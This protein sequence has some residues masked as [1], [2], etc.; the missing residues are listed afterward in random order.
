MNKSSKS[1]FFDLIEISKLDLKT[2]ELLR[3]R[4]QITPQII[5]VNRKLKEMRSSCQALLDEIDTCEK[6][7]KVYE[8]EIAEFL[9]KVTASKAKVYDIKTNEAYKMALKEID[10][11]EHEIKQREDSIL[12][13]MRVLEKNQPEVEK[14]KEKFGPEEKSLLEQEKSFKDVISE[15]ENVMNN[16]TA[17]RDK[18]SMKIDKRIFTQYERIRKAKKGIAL[19]AVHGP[20][21]EACNMGIRPQLYNQLIKGEIL[22]CPNCSRM[23]HF[24]APPAPPEEEQA[25]P[26][27]KKPARKRASKKK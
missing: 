20:N 27:K 17:E 9:E 15:C 21:C 22:S 13:L 1:K 11:W 25:P 18:S 4:N 26:A 12:E 2:V 19:V 6:K 7:K 8:E 23:L 10:N 24:E 3:K 5:E 16:I 14:L